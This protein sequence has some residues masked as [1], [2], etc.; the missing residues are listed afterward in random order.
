MAYGPPTSYQKEEEDAIPEEC[1]ASDGSRHGTALHASI[2]TSSEEKL[3]V[4]KDVDIG[5]RRGCRGGGGDRIAAHRG[6]RN[7]PIQDRARQ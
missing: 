2:G 5:G 6:K 1:R 3:G 4:R 7:Q